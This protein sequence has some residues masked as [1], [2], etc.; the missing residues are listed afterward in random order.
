METFGKAE[1]LADENTKMYL[2]EIFSEDGN[3]TEVS[4]KS[5]SVAFWC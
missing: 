2:G 5:Q 1:K 4:L 3:W